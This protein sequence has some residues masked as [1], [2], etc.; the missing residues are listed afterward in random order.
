MPR[1]IGGMYRINT[2]E[3]PAPETSNWDDVTL[4]D[5]LNGIPIISAYTQHRWQWQQMDGPTYKK[6]V[7]FYETQRS[8]NTALDVLE[9]D[10]YDVS[11]AELQYGT[12]TY[13]DFT[14]KSIG[15][16]TRGLPNYQSVEIIFEVKVR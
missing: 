5:G 6:L 14:I 4:S 7:D 15:S 2:T 16:R 9:T 12:V 10:P 13:D 8:G 3:F 11:G 1:T